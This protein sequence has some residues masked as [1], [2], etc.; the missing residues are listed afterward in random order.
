MTEEAIRVNRPDRKRHLD[1]LPTNVMAQC[2]QIADE[3]RT[4]N[5]NVRDRKVL[6]ARIRICSGYYDCDHVLRA[7]AARLLSEGPAE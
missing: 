3:I 7:V 5:H 6:A 1:D 2:K 4:Q